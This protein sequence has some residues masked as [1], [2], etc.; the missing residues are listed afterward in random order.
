MEA[1]LAVFRPICNVS[2]DLA[3]TVVCGFRL[4]RYEP[5]GRTVR[6]V[7]PVPTERV[8]RRVNVVC[9]DT[10][11]L[12]RSAFET[13][14]DLDVS[15]HF[16]MDW[17]YWNRLLSLGFRFSVLPRFQSVALR[18]EESKTSKLQHVR[19]AEVEQVYQRYLGGHLTEREALAQLR[20]RWWLGYY[21]LRLA[22]QVG[23]MNQER[24]AGRLLKLASV[25]TR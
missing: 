1:S 18:H 16:A 6:R 21:A 25:L 9:Q 2:F 20:W 13:A 4:D 7:L 19:T 3:E 17:E 5:T 11:F 23:F 12:R 22:G 24:V 15:F 8:L 10:V 14:G